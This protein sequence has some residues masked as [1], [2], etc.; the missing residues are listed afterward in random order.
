MLSAAEPFCVP[1]KPNLA[2][3][4]HVAQFQLAAMRDGVSRHVRSCRVGLESVTTR[5]VT[6]CWRSPTDDRMPQR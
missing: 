2:L 5:R 4:K 3:S 1:Q 6:T